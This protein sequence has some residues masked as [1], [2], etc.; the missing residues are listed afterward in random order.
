MQLVK[1]IYLSPM[2]RGSELAFRVLAREYGNASLCYSPMLRDHDV[3]SVAI[4]PNKYVMSREVQIDNAGRVDSIEEMHTYYC[5]MYTQL[6]ILRILW[7]NFVDH[8]QTNLLRQHW[9][10]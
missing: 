6:M 9:Q 3:I 7:Y 4:N 10:Y 2:V 8:V 1:G 5:M